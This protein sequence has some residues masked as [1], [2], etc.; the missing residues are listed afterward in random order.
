MALIFPG[1]ECK[2]CGEVIQQGDRI[3]AFMHFV[4]NSRDPLYKFTDGA[5]HADCFWRDPL[6]QEAD[7]VRTRLIEVGKNQVC[8]VCHQAITFEEAMKDDLMPFGY[9]T[10]DVASPVYKYNFLW[11]HKSHLCEWDEIDAARNAFKS[12]AGSPEWDPR[13]LGVMELVLTCPPVER[14]VLI[15]FLNAK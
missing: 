4:G 13:R 2:L 9:L 15:D 14:S 10:M 3:E 6:A 12:L 1:M 7:R 11:F 5:F 8:E